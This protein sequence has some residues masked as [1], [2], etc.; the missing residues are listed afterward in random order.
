MTVTATSNRALGD[1]ISRLRQQHGWTQRQLA[2]RAGIGLTVVSNSE[3]G[4]NQPSAA[5]L[6]ALSRAFSVSMDDLYCG[7][8]QDGE[9]AA[10]VVDTA[11]S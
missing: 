9:E 1:R 8:G 4:R 7:G 6:L 5:S 11:A 10:T 2:Y 3:Y